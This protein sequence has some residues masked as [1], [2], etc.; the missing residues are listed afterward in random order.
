MS[1]SKGK[2]V[3]Y[4]EYDDCNCDLVEPDESALRRIISVLKTKFTISMEYKLVKY[5]GG[6]SKTNISE[7]IM[8]YVQS[9]ITVDA[10]GIDDSTVDYKL[11][12][13][14]DNSTYFPNYIM[15]LRVDEVVPNYNMV[16]VTTK[17]NE[18]VIKYGNDVCLHNVTETFMR[19]VYY[20]INC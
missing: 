18:C 11:G 20:I 4:H 10:S 2:T 5:F 7:I 19:E 1:L 13:N 17:N 8:C 6:I 15:T 3:V 14:M 9:F 16:S 12:V